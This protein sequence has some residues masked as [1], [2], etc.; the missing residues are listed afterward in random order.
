MI[1][2]CLL[3]KITKRSDEVE[4]IIVMLIVLGILSRL[5][6]VKGF[7]G[8]KSVSFMLNKLDK[9]TYKVINDM[10]LHTRGGKTTQIDHVVISVYGIFVIETKN[11]KGWIFGS[12]KNKN[13]TQ[14]INNRKYSFYNPIYQNFGHIKALQ[15]F[16]EFEGDTIYHSIISFSS[17]SSLK[18]IEIDSDRIEVIQ[19]P[20]LLSTILTHREQ[21]LTELEVKRIVTRLSFIHKA[22][23]DQRKQHVTTIKSTL[24]EE[25]QKVASHICPKCDGNLIVRTGKYGSFTGCSNYPKCR[26]VVKKQA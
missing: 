8:E 17:K 3:H 26:Y 22:K 15:R 10:M 20:N 16:L 25:K 5:P 2:K 1:L 14:T 19:T 24:Q 23:R 4:I 13:W 11:Y 6:S 21:K 18:K 7:I 9:E 12:E